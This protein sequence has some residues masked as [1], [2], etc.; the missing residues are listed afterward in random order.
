MTADGRYLPVPTDPAGR[1]MGYKA[2]NYF[3]QGTAYSVLSETINTLE[4]MGLGEAINLAMHDELVVDAEAAGDVRS[5]ME[6]APWWLEQFAGN[7][8]VLRTDSN[9]L[10]GHWAYV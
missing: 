2:T 7:P 5:V 6:T 3:T 1:V 10:P 4:S 9:V 8:V